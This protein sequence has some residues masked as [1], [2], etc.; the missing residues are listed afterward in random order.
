MICAEERLS[1]DLR[2]EVDEQLPGGLAG[3]GE[4]LDLDDPADPHVDGHELLEVDLVVTFHRVG[5]VLRSARV[6]PGAGAEEAKD[7]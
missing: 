2:A 3:L 5:N 6:D 7:E 4:V 1:P